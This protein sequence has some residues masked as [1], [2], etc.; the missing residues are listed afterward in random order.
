MDIT[1]L[2][3]EYLAWEDSTRDAIRIRR[4]YVD[5]AGDLNAGIL[6]SQLCYWFGTDEYGQPR[7]RICRDDKFWVARQRTEWWTDCCLTPKQFDSAV[8]KL[9]RL[10]ADVSG[11]LSP[12]VE[13]QLYQF[14]GTPV[15]HVHLNQ[16]ALAV[17]W[18]QQM[19]KYKEARF[20][21]EG[22]IHFPQTVKSIFPKREKPITKNTT[23]NTY[24]NILANEEKIEENRKTTKRIYYPSDYTEGGDLHTAARN[25][26][27][28]LVYHFFASRFELYDLNEEIPAS[29]FAMYF[30]T[31]KKVITRFGGLDEAIKFVE[32]ALNSDDKFIGQNAFS[33]S[34]IFCDSTYNKYTAV[35]K[36]LVDPRPKRLQK[37]VKGLG[38]RNGTGVR[39]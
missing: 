35:I 14:N 37:H 29:R 16:A 26:A 9:T 32:W 8:I 17:L 2:V 27:E 28:K 3:A 22:Q 19:Q 5:I 23:E 11:V 34:V 7:V 18:K 21:P 4:C 30:R 24:Y 38:D 1:E 15:K 12:L 20:S 31:A 13:T 6:L 39:Y 36:D 25:D 10:T 33:W